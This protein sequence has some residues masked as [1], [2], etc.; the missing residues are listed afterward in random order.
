MNWINVAIGVLVYFLILGASLGWLRHQS[1]INDHS[2]YNNKNKRRRRRW[3]RIS[4]QD[5]PH[6]GRQ[7]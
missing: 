4:E 7:S 3:N 2:D 1:W 6:P 5:R